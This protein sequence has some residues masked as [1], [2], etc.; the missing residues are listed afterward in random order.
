MKIKKTLL[1]IAVLGVAIASNAQ[2]KDKKWG[3][4]FSF[5]SEQYRGE[6][7]SGDFSD[8]YD[9][10]QAFNGFGGIT[11]SRYL[12]PHLDLSLQSTFGELRHRNSNGSPYNF[13]YNMFQINMNLKYSFF[14]Y[15]TAKVRPFVFAGLGHMVFTDKVASN[16]LRQTQL[17]NFGLGLSYRVSPTVSIV[18]Q[19]TFMYSDSD[20]I[21]NKT[22]VRKNHNDW[23]G[24]HSIGVMFNLGSKKDSDKDGVADKHD[25]CP[26]IAGLKLFDGCPDT[27]GDGIPDSEDKCPNEKG[28]P[29]FNGCPDT[30]G[31]GIPDKDDRCPNEK[32]S[33]ALK[34]CP[35]SDGDGVADKDDECPNVAGTVNGCP[36]SDGDGVADK[37]DA[38]PNV[39]GTANGCPDADGDGV[40]D[41]D[42]ACP[43]IAGPASNNGCPV[44][45]QPVEAIKFATGKA[46]ITNASSSVLGEL[47]TI[48]KE[49]KSYKLRVE[50][51]TD[52]EGS[53][54]FNLDLSNRRANAVKAYLVK[55][56]IA[57]DR[58]TAKGFG[59][60]KPVADNSTTAG[61]AKNRR[62]ELII[63]F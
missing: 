9:F 21:D 25:K 35:D 59:K 26:E 4:G 36:D 23:Y 39:A 7:G 19:E 20:F 57:A 29:E 51:H 22:K 60:T 16:N 14:K 62:V 3:L 11:I 55:N 30:D 40:A 46:N 33:K 41:K 10:G 5:G 45:F 48:L 15:E 54:A 12:T 17:P 6:L 2:T 52:S 49:N 53:D 32:G 18:L 42:D 13:S 47:V 63:R 37:D 56:G 31:D 27:D 61:K 1:L 24:Q 43:N 44:D 58:L 28:L 50:G 34:G 38:C 8:F